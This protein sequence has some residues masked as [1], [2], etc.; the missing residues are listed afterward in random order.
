MF[1]GEFEHNIDQKGR[2][3]I[4][5]R[6]RDSFGDGLVLTRG[7]EKCIV[8][9]PLTEWNKVAERL[10]AL[11]STQSRVRRISRST[12]SSAF[13]QEL[14]GQGR[15]LVPPPLREYAGINGDVVI[16]GVNNYI[17][18][19]S[20]ANWASE[21]ATMEQEAWQLAEGVEA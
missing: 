6:L 1:L 12:F 15:V 2:V 13:Q 19:W 17:E 14:D 9:Y 4:P 7:Y 18:I 16:V 3:A 5:S 20:K 11:P 10:A 8:V 21:S